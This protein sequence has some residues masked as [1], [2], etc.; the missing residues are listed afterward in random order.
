MD[1]ATLVNITMYKL[2]ESL[3]CTTETNVT[4]WQLYSNEKNPQSV[5]IEGLLIIVFI[6]TIIHSIN[7]IEVF[8]VYVYWC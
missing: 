2:V 8:L 1:K 4:L 6:I 7:L 5:T 3:F